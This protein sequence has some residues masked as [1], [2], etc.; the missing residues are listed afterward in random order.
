MTLV[1]VI[2]TATF[3]NALATAGYA[4]SIGGEFNNGQNVINARNTFSQCGYSSYY[5]NNPTYSYVSSS[6]RL[7]SDV[8]YFSSHGSKNSLH[9]K[10]D[11]FIIDNYTPSSSIP[12]GASTIN[13][14]NYTLSNA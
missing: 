5:T 1:S 11:I 9:L 12:S 7:N 6:S 8:V 13:I 10:N 3:Y 14:R 4:Y 2:I